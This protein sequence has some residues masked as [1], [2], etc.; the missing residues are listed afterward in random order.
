MQW[1]SCYADVTLT[2]SV[3][4]FFLTRLFQLSDLLS[5]WDWGWLSTCWLR[6]EP[7]QTEVMLRGQGKQLWE[8]A[9]IT[10]APLIGGLWPRG[11]PLGFSAAAGCSRISCGPQPFTLHQARRRQWLPTMPLSRQDWATVMCAAWSR[12]WGPLR[13]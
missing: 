8:E 9:K 11:E 7:D 5:C 10:S 1:C 3:S 2:S 6:L 12:A 4:L 13:S